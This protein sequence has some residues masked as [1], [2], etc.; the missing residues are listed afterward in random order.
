MKAI[1]VPSGEKLGLLQLPIRAIAGLSGPYNFYPF[2]YDQVR[3]TFGTAPSP[4]GTQPGN[5]VTSDA[6][7]IF[8]AIGT[9]C[10]I[11]RIEDSEALHPR[12][13]SHSYPRCVAQE[14]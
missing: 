7:P 2:E 6:P 3:D 1:R 8:L 12:K 11:V 4:E 13:Y 5:L 9:S 10:P 14:F